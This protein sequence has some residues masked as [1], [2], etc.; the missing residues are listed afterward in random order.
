MPEAPRAAGPEP[1]PNPN[2]ML[3]RGEPLQVSP[4][5][6][7]LCDWGIFD[8]STNRLPPPTDPNTVS[9][10]IP[11]NCPLETI[12]FEAS[13]PSSCSL[14]TAFLCL[15]HKHALK[16]ALPLSLFECLVTH[17]VLPV[18]RADVVL[19]PC[20]QICCLCETAEP[21]VC[22]CSTPSMGWCPLPIPVISFRDSMTL[23]MLTQGI[24][25]LAV[26]NCPRLV[27]CSFKTAAALQFARGLPQ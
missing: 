12:A 3:C 13:T 18:P 25:R 16:D 5:Y 27:Y 19:Q 6:Q 17:A 1:N 7:K 8:P 9:V 4:A 14:I 26:K 23:W 10:I 22:A 21:M 20:R 11:F 24:W 2:P 15:Q